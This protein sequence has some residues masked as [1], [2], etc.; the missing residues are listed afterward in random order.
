MVMRLGVEDICS[1]SELVRSRRLSMGYSRSELS[2]LSGVSESTIK[3]IE[4]NG[5][6]TL[7]S[8]LRILDSLKL[9]TEI[10]WKD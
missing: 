5:L 10:I 8:Y 4:S 1:I 7:G 9:K 3:R 6:V 2:E